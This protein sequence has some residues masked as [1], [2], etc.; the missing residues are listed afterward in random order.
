MIAT[1]NGDAERRR[2]YPPVDVK[3]IR[4][5]SGMT[6]EAFASTYG[7]TLGALRDWEQGRKRPERTARILLRVIVH[8]PDTVARAAAGS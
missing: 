4:K 7:F 1:T 5:A 8:A 6:Q 3:A 2:E